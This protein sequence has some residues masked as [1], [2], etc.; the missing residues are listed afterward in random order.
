MLTIFQR[1]KNW[2][3]YSLLWMYVYQCIQYPYR[4]EKAMKKNEKK[5]VCFS[6]SDHTS[7]TPNWTSDYRS[8]LKTNKDS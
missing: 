8:L 3:I 2:S 5:K 1:I 6:P 4:N 7:K